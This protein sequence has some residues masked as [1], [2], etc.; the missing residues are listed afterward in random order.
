MTI[1]PHY[2]IFRVREVLN[3]QRVVV[4]LDS[5]ST[6][7]FIDA[8]LVEKCGLQIEKHEGFDVRVAGG[9]NLSSTHKVPK[10]SITLGNY[11]VIDDF[12][13]DDK[14]VVLW[15]MS[16]SGPRIVS[17]KRMEAI[18]RHGDVS[19]VPKSRDML[20]EYQDILKSLKENLQCAQNQHKIYADKKRV[21]R[22]F[23]IG[24]LVYLRLQPYRR[25]SLKLSGAEKLKPWF[26]GSYQVVRKV[27]AV[28]Y[29]LDLP[30]GSKI[31]NV[32]HVSCFKKA[33]G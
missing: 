33:L 3:G 21:E 1:T 11:T 19:N 32:F 12:Y 28:A 22:H 23:E 17:V 7:N 9:T 29:E 30:V 6:H 16:N 15:G 2:N 24:K 13:I 5:G 8:A 31:H 27:G 26:Y 4:M 25:P 10:L 20:Q 18:F 14:K